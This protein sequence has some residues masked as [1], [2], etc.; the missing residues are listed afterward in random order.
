MKPAPTQRNAVK[1]KTLILGLLV[2]LLC[3]VGLV[4][5]I[6]LSGGSTHVPQSRPG[7]GF[8]VDDAGAATSATPAGPSASGPATAASAVRDE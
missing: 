3:A 8:G 7:V 1:G 6:G 4:F 5:W 2:A